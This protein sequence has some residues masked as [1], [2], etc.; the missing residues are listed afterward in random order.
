MDDDEIADFIR[1]QV[2]DALRA[3]GSIAISQ[4]GD[5]LAIPDCD[6]PHT[7]HVTFRP[8]ARVVTIRVPYVRNPA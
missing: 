1:A 7:I 8:R 5:T 4:D 3:G 2:I 6:E